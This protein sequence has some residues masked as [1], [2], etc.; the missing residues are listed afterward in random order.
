V[1]LLWNLMG[2]GFFG[3]ELFAQEA[4]IEEWSEPQKEW[5]RSTPAWIYV[6][7]GL[8]VTAGVAGSAGLLMRKAWS[9]LVLAIGL[10]AVV[11]QMV[12]TMLIAGGLEVMGPSSLMLPGIIILVAGSLLWFS[13]FASAKGWL[14]D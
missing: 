1:A 8:A 9:V 14:V 12:Y 4:A 2:C 10:G 6:V 3:M 7:Y 11:I 5:A 13:R